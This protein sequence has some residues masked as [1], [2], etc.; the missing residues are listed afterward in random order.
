M[1]R[2]REF[3]LILKNLL[4][5][6]NVYFQPPEN[7]TMKYPA[8]VYHLDDMNTAHA[9]NDPYRI[10][11]G[12]LVTYIDRNPDSDMPMKLARLRTADFDRQFPSDGLYHTV[13]SIY[14]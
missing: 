14:Y 4:G 13:F 11:K 7:V 1:D 6:E 8:I 3:H 10:S 9:N 5:S 12:Y 2:R